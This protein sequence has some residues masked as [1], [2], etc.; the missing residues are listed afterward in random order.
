MVKK[1]RTKNGVVSMTER[2]EGLKE[3]LEEK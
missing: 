1:Y 2:L 3:E